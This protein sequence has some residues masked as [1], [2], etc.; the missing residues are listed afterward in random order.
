MNRLAP[1][2][3]KILLHL[4]RDGVALAAGLAGPASAADPLAARRELVFDD[5]KGHRA[6][7]LRPVGSQAIKGLGHAEVIAVAAGEIRIDGRPFGPGRA[8]VLPRGF[9]GEIEASPATLAVFVSQ[10]SPELAPAETGLITLDPALPRNPSPGPAASVLIG[11]VPKTHSLNQ[12][13][14][15]SG[16]RAGIWDV[17][18]PCERSVVPHRIHELMM[19]LEGEVTLTHQS[20]GPAT[21]RAGDI[22]FVPQGA[23]YAWKNTITVVKVYTVSG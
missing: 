17:S 1:A 21:F 22:L 8:F 12:F 7:Y 19:L 3:S 23:P 20:E 11:P 5:G 2:T 4:G 13:T 16:F 6:G 14:D 10:E 9:T 18:S 15:G